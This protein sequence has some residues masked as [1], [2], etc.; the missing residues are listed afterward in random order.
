MDLTRGVFMT[1]NRRRRQIRWY[2][3]ITAIVLGGATALALVASVQSASAATAATPW[4]AAPAWQSYGQAPSSA[5]VCPTA[6]VSTAGAVTGAAN[7][8]CGGTGGATLTATSGGTAPTIVLDYGKNIG[9]VPY[10]TVTSASGSPKLKARYLESKRYLTTNGD[11]A[12][13]GEGDPSRSDTYTVT[14]AGTITNRYTQGGERYEEITLVSPG[15]VSLS[16]IGVTYIADRTQASAYQGYFV[17]S[18][19]QMNR[20]WYDSAYT[21]QLDSVPT[22]SLPGVWAIQNGV[23][24]AM[25]GGGNSSTS[26]NSGLL[27]AGAD[28]TD[29]T[30]TFDA[31]VTNGQ[32]G[33]M[34]RGQDPSNGYVFILDT[35]DDTAGP[36]NTV[37]E[38][39]VRDGT[40]TSVG[41]ATL[42]S[43]LASG[44]WHTLSTTVSGSTVTV[45]F[46]GTQIASLNSSSFPA[47][48]PTYAKGSAG[49]REYGTEQAN[50]RNL[51]VVNSAGATLYGNALSTPAS[52]GDFAVPNVNT[53]PSIVD[54]ARR[55]RAVW[56]GD[57]DV[58]GPAVYY[59]TGASN[60]LKGSLQLLGSYQLDSGFVT[61]AMPP[62]ATVHTGAKIPGTVTTYSASYSMYYVLG[63]ANYYLY[64]D[65]SAFLN[66]A[67]PIAQAELAWNATQL[68][69]RGLFVTNGGDG[70]DWDFYD[71][72]KSG[73]VSEVN[74]IYYKTLL[75]GAQLAT[76]VGQT[77]LAA[78]YT[79]RAAAL[80]TA[81]NTY[82]FNAG[83]GVYTIS[84]TNT[85]VP[86]DA[87]SMAVL[88]GV[89]S[90]TQASSI[91]SNIKTALWTS[92]YGPLPYT[93]DAGYRAVISPFISGYELQARLAS[94]DTANAEALLGNVWGHMIADGPD[95]THTMWE[96]VLA[97]DGTP[98]LGADTNLSHGW[99]AGPTGAL[100]GYVLGI[101]PVTAGYATWSV[102]PHPGSLSWAKGQA[103]TPHGALAVSWAGNSG[104][105][106]FSMQVTAPTGTTGTIAVPTYD[107]TNPIVAVNGTVVW[108][109]GAFTATGGVTGAHADANFVYL[110]GVQPGTYTVASN[111]GNV[112]PPTGYTACAAENGTCS[113][114]GTQSVAFGA[115]GIYSYQTVTGGTACD[116][117]TL[118]DVDFGFVKGC[119]T[120]PVT[121][122]PSGS[123]FCA[124]ENGLCSFSGTRT[125]AYGAGS[126]FTTKSLTGGTPCTNDVFKD[127]PPNVVKACFLI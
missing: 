25:G 14:G 8:L 15:T 113:F 88:Y 6:V 40:Y 65:D 82:L 92:P 59:S 33:W 93:S 61:G 76:A 81:I 63:L 4:P 12:P 91:L 87:N 68:D 124:P 127:L 86:Q 95:Q 56:S 67:W 72:P 43:P 122:G 73:A 119:Y 109:G 89:A 22:G 83:K 10:L 30:M 39:S 35:A 117:T 19:D 108:S 24:N 112:G 84:D 21:A 26:G 100:S 20:I 102:Q 105:R 11:T 49:F 34:V 101:K 5:A 54:G 29:Y 77:A 44:S 31:N 1:L 118:T 111:P 121:T 52:L 96:N 69:S 47:G 123:T 28:W 107:A 60:Y 17:S 110:T 18:S 46:D 50:F 36:P 78:T 53:I 9:G 27:K 32:A 125:V 71:N 62:Q 48:A 51:T 75:D 2:A 115:N 38:L 55:D 126:T 85:A 7:L 13:W 58:E 23:L 98:G 106:Q 57:L 99:S 94:N 66:T 3:T 37:Q 97:S 116:A 104:V 74:M 42:P 41:T 90:A 64:T 120:G 70:N 114:T 16:G 103:P 80:K 79:S 45:S